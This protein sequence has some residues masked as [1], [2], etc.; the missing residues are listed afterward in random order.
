[1]ASGEI[2]AL[3]IATPHFQHTTLGIAAL[4]AGLH[5][6]GLH[7]LINR[8]SPQEAGYKEA[9]YKEANREGHPGYCAGYKE[10]KR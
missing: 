7:T 4:E 2:D 9:G 6:M 10:G 3:M 1:M 8:G 5:I